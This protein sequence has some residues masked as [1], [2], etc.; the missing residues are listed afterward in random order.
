MMDNAG[1]HGTNV[2]ILAYTKMLKDSYNIVIIH[3][4]QRSP[5]TNLLH[6]GVWCSLQAQVENSFPEKDRH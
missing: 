3:Q 4:V 1:G 6:L 5:Y 2:T